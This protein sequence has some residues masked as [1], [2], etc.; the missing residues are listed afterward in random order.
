MLHRLIHIDP[1][2]PSQLIVLSRRNADSALE[3][4]SKVNIAVV[5]W[6]RLQALQ[7]PSTLR[8]EL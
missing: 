5:F 7:S 3:A 2:S 8:Y 6:T 1:T 4:D